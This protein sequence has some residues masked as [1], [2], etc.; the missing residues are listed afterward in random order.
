MQG[1]PEL[2]P[3]LVLNSD[4]RP[5]SYYP[6][7]LWPWQD[8]VKAVFL[9][10][11]NVVEEYEKKVRSPGFEM[12]LPSV[13]AWVLPLPHLRRRSKLRQPRTG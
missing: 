10:R 8:V 13:V 11:V 12:R 3:A 6:L 9:D 2:A 5:L 1:L 7:S 4:Y